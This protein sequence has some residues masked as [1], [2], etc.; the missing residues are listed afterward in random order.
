MRLPVRSAR[1]P[2]NRGC[3]SGPGS[4]RR[5]H[6][7]ARPPW[8]PSPLEGLALTVGALRCTGHTG[9]TEHT[10][11]AGLQDGAPGRLPA[12][13]ALLRSELEDHLQGEKWVGSLKAP[14]TNGPLPKNDVRTREDNGP[15]ARARV[16]HPCHGSPQEHKDGVGP[17]LPGL[18]RA[19]D[20]LLG[21]QACAGRAGPQWRPVTCGWRLA[22]AKI[23]A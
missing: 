13:H 14:P 3:S 17:A 20:W 16:G 11:L 7:E 23:R 4:R 22:S 9:L 21:G 12:H 19:E 6:Q 1:I 18:L 5:W 10:V 2:R 8:L 15:L